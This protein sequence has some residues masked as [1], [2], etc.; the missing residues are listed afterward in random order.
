MFSRPRP[1]RIAGSLALV[2]AAAL[3]LA[4]CSTPAGSGEKTEGGTITFGVDVDP[5]GHLD[6]HSSQLDINAIL[7][8][9]VFDSLVSQNADGTIVPWLATSW[10]VSD[11]GLQYTFDLRDDVTFS[12][13]EKFDAA[14][15]K[16]N[17]DH[18]V[19]PATESAQASSLIGGEYY[20]GTEVIDDTTVRVNFSQPYA[21]FLANAASVEL[22]F[23]SPKVLAEHADELKAGG[24]GISV[25]SGPF[26]LSEYTPGSEL[27]YTRNP[28]Y[29]WA[30]EGA[31]AQGPATI[32]ELDVKI[33]PESSVRTSA[34]TSGQVDVI[35]DTAP[36]SL[37][38]IGD[39]F[40]VTST[41]SPGVPY[42]LYLNVTRPVF[43][44]VEVRKA[45]AGGFDLDA[46]VKAVFSD[47]Y[48]RAYSILGPTTPDSYD[49]AL[50][51]S[52]SFDADAANDALDAAGWSERD[53]DGYRTKNGERLSARWISYTPVNEDNANLANL[54]QDGLK[55]IGFEVVH[56][57][58]EPGAYLDA[59]LAGDYDLTDWGF[60]SADAD[61]L[62]SHL[63]TGGYQNASHLS[64]PEIDATLASAVAT[65]DASQRAELYTQL[66]QWNAENAVIV[67]LYVPEYI[68][69]SSKKVGGIEVDI[70]GWPLFSGAYVTK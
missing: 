14:A 53:S 47:S 57:Q 42:S 27:V 54:I 68:L 9:P 15:V 61:V 16:A 8:R 5:V 18:I 17:F 26:I 4:G 49:A 12:D 24:P 2:T 65:T 11:D 21:P 62:R 56:D 28:D 43:S 36:S 63:G 34:L 55:K 39:G 44:D 52:A 33:L 59:Y 25:G 48:Q 50:E 67:P 30:P 31:T 60:L 10:Q 23:Y 13:G 35:G 41:E 66:Q 32:D 29:D 37:D 38:Q 7:Q 58:L 46:A 40:T 22:G 45:F 70:H 20:A 19:D 3:V 69:A 64:D 51:T 6:V 1:L